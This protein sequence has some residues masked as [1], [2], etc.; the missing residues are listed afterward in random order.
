M[1]LWM[2]VIRQLNFAIDIC[3]GKVDCPPADEFCTYEL[4]QWPVA[5]IPFF[6]SHVMIDC[7]IWMYRR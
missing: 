5:D 2:W 4:L 7:L 1:N 6:A 3:E